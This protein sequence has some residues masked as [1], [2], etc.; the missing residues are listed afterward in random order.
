[1]H[2]KDGEIQAGVVAMG[3]QNFFITV[4]MFFGAILLSFAFPYKVYLR[5]RLDEEGR[6]IPMQRISSKLVETLNPKDI[7]ED[8]VHNFIPIYHKYAL[9][10]G[11][12]EDLNERPTK[13]ASSQYSN[14][15]GEG[16][17]NE[18]TCMLTSDSEI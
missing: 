15:E 4:E 2:G 10:T 6:G 14:Y 5:L 1:M 13:S 11:V 17:V 7:V 18:R 9:H 3:Y 12:A 8:A 16:E